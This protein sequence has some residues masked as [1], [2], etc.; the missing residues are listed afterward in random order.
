MTLLNQKNSMISS[1]IRYWDNS[2]SESVMRVFAGVSTGRP[3]NL[4]G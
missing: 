3:R 4:N 2:E 1:E